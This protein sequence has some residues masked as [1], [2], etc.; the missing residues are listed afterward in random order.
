[1]HV[2]MT[3]ASLLA[4]ISR[5]AGYPFTRSR[6]SRSMDD[7]VTSGRQGMPSLRR[8]NFCSRLAAWSKPAHPTLPLSCQR[9]RGAGEAGSGFNRSLNK[10]PDKRSKIMRA[11][12]TGLWVKGGTE[13]CGHA[14]SR[15]RGRRSVA[16]PAVPGPCLW[17][18]QLRPFPLHR[19]TGSDAT[20]R[21]VALSPSSQPR[22]E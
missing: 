4:W 22:R 16:L 5:S 20:P 7:L 19:A 13:A 10:M 14:T 3:Q 21:S 15:P 12:L 2:R 11:V 17:Y 6:G 8:G 1:M 9:R 18:S